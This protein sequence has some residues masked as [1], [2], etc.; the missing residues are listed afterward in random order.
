MREVC[1]ADSACCGRNES[2]TMQIRGDEIEGAGAGVDADDL[3]LRRVMAM[4]LPGDA[5]IEIAR[6]QD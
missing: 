6:L 4:A 5:D 3:L 1:E 2:W